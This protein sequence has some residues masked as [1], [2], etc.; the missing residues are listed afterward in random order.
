[1][2]HRLGNSNTCHVPRKSIAFLMAIAFILSLSYFMF[3]GYRNWPYKIESDGKYYYQYLVSIVY[4]ADV[5]FSNNYLENKQSWMHTDIDHYNLKEKIH[6][7]TRK[8]VNYF[9]VGPSILWLPFL[10]ITYGMVHLADTVWLRMDTSPWSRIF[11]YS[12]MYSAVVY[13]VI[14]LYLLMRLGERYFLKSTCRIAAWLMLVSTNLYYYA[15]FEPSMSHVYDLFAYLL[16]LTLFLKCMQ[17]PRSLLLLLLGLSAALHVLVRAQNILSVAVLTLFMISIFVADK[18]QNILGLLS[19]YGVALILGVMPIM[20]INVYLYGEPLVMPQGSGFLDLKNPKIL[21]VLFSDRNG[22]FSTHPVLLF[23]CVGVV[24]LSWELARKDEYRELAFLAIMATI[25]FIQV[26]IN[27]AT[28]DWW[29][30]HAFGQ[31]RLLSAMPIFALGI[32]C[33]VE[34]L[35]N[36]RKSVLYGCVATFTAMGFYLTFIHVFVWN[37]DSPHRLYEWMI[38]YP[39]NKFAMFCNA[40]SEK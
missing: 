19:V 6:P 38:I 24:V 10:M 9:S 30:G 40:F 13:T 33:I 18:R 31:R 39:L 35:A 26:Y 7:A 28:S 2:F 1:M 14:S 37:Y 25:F 8:P 36:W 20:M 3:G 5:D 4:D 17:E 11:Q 22:Y 15:V 16:M 29:A 32:A 21:Q 34:K 27:S 12:V 23:G